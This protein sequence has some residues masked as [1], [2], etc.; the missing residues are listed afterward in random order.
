MNS[1]ALY[2]APELYDA[3]FGTYRADHAFYAQALQR[4]PGA[5]VEVGCGTG[6]LFVQHAM[7]Q[8]AYVGVDPSAA[9]LARAR[10]RC[11]AVSG[12]PRFVEADARALPVRPGAAALVVLA[13]NML[14]H[15]MDAASLQAALQQAANVGR[16]VAFDVFMPP[17]P[18]GER[19][20]ALFGG[21]ERRKGPAGTAL[22]VTEKTWVD[23]APDARVQHTLLQ[24][25]PEGPQGLTMGQTPPGPAEVVLG[26]SRRLWP[27]EALVDACRAAGL[28]PEQKWGDV[29]GCAWTPHSPRL[30]MVA[31]AAGR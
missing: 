30:M 3:E 10:V 15:M 31:A 4:H 7:A 24:F 6:R 5:V 21:E 12:G 26:V 20:D 29:D 2:Q 14:Q 11:A 23:G 1:T 8:N 17:N 25:V 13:Y 27:A 18:G 19:S 9:M 22:R 28:V 16:A